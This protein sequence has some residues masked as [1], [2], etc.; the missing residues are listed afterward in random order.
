MDVGKHRPGTYPERATAYSVR[1]YSPALRRKRRE[2]DQAALRHA[3]AA[4]RERPGQTVWQ[5]IKSALGCW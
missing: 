1:A 5:R 4:H 2:R 3:L